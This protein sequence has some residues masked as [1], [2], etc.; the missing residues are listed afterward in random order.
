MFAHA[1]MTTFEL[2]ARL[3]TRKAA[4]AWLEKENHCRLS[5]PE[6]QTSLSFAEVAR[7]RLSL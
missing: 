6:C 1:I 4:A 5:F 2:L 7:F 3:P